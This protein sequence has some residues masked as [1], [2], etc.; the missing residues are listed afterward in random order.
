MNND[1]LSLSLEWLREAAH[2]D[3]TYKKLLDR[4]TH[5]TFAKSAAEEDSDIRQYFNVRDCLSVCNDIILYTFEDCTPRIVI[6]RCLQSSVKKN[7]HA[8]HQGLSTIMLCARKTVYWPGMEKSLQAITDAC[9][10]CREHAKSHTKEPLIPALIP[11]YRMQYVASDLFEYEGYKYLVYACRLTGWV[12]LGF[13]PTTTKSTDVINIVGDFFHRWGVPEEIAI[14]GASNLSSTEFRTFLDDWSVR[15][16]L[17]SAYYP[18]SNGRA[19]TAVKSMKR[20][21]RGNTSHRGSLDIAQGLLQYRNTPLQNAAGKSP[22][23]LALGR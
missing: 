23:Q 15:H 7:L 4:I 5:Q 12:E 6:P 11:D 8:A 20:L 2:T 21:I 22:A 3:P 19:D 17:S 9:P 1:N 10:Q 16:R 14:D 13:F 18:Q